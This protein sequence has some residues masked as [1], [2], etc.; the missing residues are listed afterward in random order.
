MEHHLRA[1]I[2]FNGS[3]KYFSDFNQLRRYLLFYTAP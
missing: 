1:I 2:R 3:F